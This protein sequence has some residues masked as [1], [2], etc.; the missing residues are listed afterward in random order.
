MAISVPNTF[1]LLEQRHLRIAFLG[2]LLDLGVVLSDPRRDRFQCTQHGRECDLQLRTQR[3]THGR[4]EAL[5]VA[6]ADPLSEGL[7]QSSCRI[8]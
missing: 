6:T 3:F 2:E 1:D 8:D 7:R 5:R 4:S